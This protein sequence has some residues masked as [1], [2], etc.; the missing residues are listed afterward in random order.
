[1][2]SSTAEILDFL[3]PIIVDGTVIYFDDWFYYSGHPFRGER[4]AFNEWLAKHPEFHATELC[5][6]YP[7]ASYILS[8]VDSDENL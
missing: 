7:A 3:T 1:L 5:K 4:G 2:Y 6:Y 8:Y